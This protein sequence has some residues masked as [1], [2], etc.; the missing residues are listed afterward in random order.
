VAD[1]L[2]AW[3]MH[4][5]IEV[6]PQALRCPPLDSR[7]DTLSGGEKRRVA[8]SQLILSEPDLMLLDEPTNHLDAQ[9]VSW[10]EQFLGNYRGSV[11]AVTHDRY[12]LDNI[13]GWM[14]EIDRGQV[15]TYQG[16][17]SEWLAQKQNRLNTE[18]KKDQ[19]RSKQLARELEW[20]RSNRSSKHKARLNAYE[21]L[22]AEGGDGVD[23]SAGGAIVIPDGPRLGNS[24]IDAQGLKLSFDGRTLFENLSFTLHRETIVGVVGA[25]GAGKSTL[26]RLL[27]GDLQPEEGTIT[28]GDTVRLGYVDQSRAGLDPNRTVYE[29]IAD[30]VETVK[31]KEGVSISTRAFAAQFNFKGSL[32]EK[33]VGQCSG[34]ERNR[35]HIAK[36]VKG[37]HNVLLLDEPTNDLDVD[38]LRSLEEALPSFGGCAVVISHDRYFL[39]RICTDIISFEGDGRVEV[40]SGNWS[41]YETD[42]KRRHAEKNIPQ[43]IEVGEN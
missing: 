26:F 1:R 32:Q 3:D 40:F 25:N 7:V 16:N 34:G 30:G 17:Y 19:A 4:R 12:F 39:D 37:G 21:D 18:H 28:I 2:G 23:A 15:Y 38:T 42:V 31:Y 35:V 27:T 11:V 10:L 36:M 43:S 6:T 41:E 8:L 24:V 33:K 14:V 5:Q 13:A 20:I 29:E 9:S 22:L